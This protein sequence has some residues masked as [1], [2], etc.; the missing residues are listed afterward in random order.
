MKN[1]TIRRGCFETNSSSTHSVTIQEIGSASRFAEPLVEDN[2]LYADRLDS[3][4]VCFDNGSSETKCVSFEQKAAIVAHWIKDL[5]Y[6][7][8][9]EEIN[10]LLNYYKSK[11]PYTDIILDRSTF[12]PY[13]DYSKNHLDCNDDLIEQVDKLLE[14]IYDDKI[15]I[16]D[17]S[18]SY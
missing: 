14:Y 7:V 12:C 17:S 6:N 18:S 13:S 16:V 15:E 10:D 5:V 2:F 3:H 8:D 4:T 9:D 11:L 1:K